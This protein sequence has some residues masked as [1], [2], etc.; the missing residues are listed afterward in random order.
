MRIIVTGA[1]GFI[2][3]SLSE[4]LLARDHDVIGID[5]LTDYYS[6]AVKRGN[7]NAALQSSRFTFLEE[8]L[9]DIDLPKVLDGCDVVFHEAAQAGVRESWGTTFQLY[10]DYNVLATQRLL[11]AAKAVPIKKFIFASSSSVYGNAERIPV[12]ESDPLRPLSPYGVTKLAGEHL[13]HLYFVN[14]GVPALSLRYFTVFGPRQRPDMAFHKFISALLRDEPLPLFGTGQQTRDFTY[15]DDAVSA[16]LCAIEKGKPGAVYNIGGGA[17]ISLNEAIELLEEISGRKAR[18]KQV[19]SQKGDV[20][21]TWADTFL[22]RKELG[23]Q[24]RFNV[25]EGLE[26]EFEWLNKSL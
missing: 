6:P 17:R 23:F 19:G 18:R 24:P 8:N 13:C 15:I 14:Y 11:E 12:C 22:A 2:G 9:L 20:L 1:A 5:C 7:L 25:V 4:A 21:H 16:N 10:S 3:S 26:R